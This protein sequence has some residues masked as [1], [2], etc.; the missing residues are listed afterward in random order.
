MPA[1]FERRRSRPDG[2]GSD[3]GT[4]SLES[5]GVRGAERQHYNVTLAV[6]ALAGLAFALQQT[7]IVPALP[8]LQRDL[9][10]TTGWVDV[11]AHRV[12]ARLGGRDT[13]PRQAR[14]PVR[15]GA[16]PARQPARL[17]RRLRGGDLR[18]EH[19]VADRASA[20][21]RA[22]AAPS[23]RSRSRSSSTSSRARR[24]ARG[25]GMISAILGIGGGLGLVLSGRARRA[26]CRGSWLFIVG[27][28]VRRRRR[29]R[30]SW[31]FVPESP[32]KTPSK[33]DP[34]GALLLLGHC[35]SRCCSR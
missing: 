19:L 25:V 22:S 27:A 18:V 32:V 4:P 21:S 20:R 14:R 16:L 17:L 35:S 6:L 10:T 29:D 3:G 33:L 34:L 30:A 23:S 28:L 5:P 11:A 26:R 2:A 9:H 13:G 15:Q 12:P 7:M 1:C 24:S 8:T 31:R